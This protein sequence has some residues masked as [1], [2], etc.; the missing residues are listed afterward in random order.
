MGVVLYD[1][2]SAWSNRSEPPDVIGA[3]FLNTLRAIE[4]QDFALTDWD[5]GEAEGDA[6]FSI[7]QLRETIGEFVA[8]QDQSDNVG[9]PWGGYLIG[10][11]SKPG[12]V[13]SGSRSACFYVRAGSK[14]LNYSSFEIGSNFSPPEA[15]IITFPLFRSVLLTM[16]S[17]WPAP[18]ASARCSIWGEK[19]KTLPGEPAFPYSGFQM[20]WLSYL[21]SE[22]AASVVVPPEIKTER[23]PDGGLLM[24]AAETRFDPTN[25]EHMRPSRLMAQIMI[26]HAADPVW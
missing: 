19:P 9:D 1:I 14:F 16:I 22:R 26:D 21:N 25:V 5:I 23:T 15:I 17:L 13:N 12:G 4:R 10:A 11:V 3:K 2:S 20:P 24:I 7:E 18:W 6:T 8:A